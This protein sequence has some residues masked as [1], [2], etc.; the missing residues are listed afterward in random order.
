MNLAYAYAPNHA[1]MERK[2][3]KSYLSQR[4]TSLKI[5][6]K[7]TSSECGGGT[8]TSLKVRGLKKSNVSSL[9]F[10]IKKNKRI[11]IND[12]YSDGSYCAF[13]ALDTCGN[14]SDV[15]KLQG[16][17]SD[18]KTL[19]KHLVSER[20]FQVIGELFNQEAT[21]SNFR[22]LM[23]RVKLVLADKPNSRF[24][25]F[26]A[27]HT[28]Y[29]HACD[30]AWISLYGFNKSRLEETSIEIRELKSYCARNIS[31][32]QLL[33]LDSCHTGML[34]MRTRGRFSNGNHLAESPCALAIAATSAN[35][36]ALETAKGGLFTSKII[37]ALNSVT[38]GSNFFTAHEL[39]STIQQHVTEQ[40]LD[41]FNFTQTP[42]MGSLFLLHRNGR[43]CEG[44]MLFS[45]E[46]P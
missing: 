24:I 21:S 27:C 5:Q 37:E 12:I 46:L 22:K 17:V 30:E 8:S 26:L 10:E 44:S 39:F 29:D 23:G 42:S 36:E 32:H 11:G 43:K 3:F 40:A 38:R 28:I 6:K 16:A 1:A 4:S 18:A 45:R 34:F 20:K 14:D 7:Q 33:L 35:G 31:K 25:M 19:Q 41:N 15:T 13:V 2:A 9:K